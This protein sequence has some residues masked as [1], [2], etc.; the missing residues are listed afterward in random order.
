MELVMDKICSCHVISPCNRGMLTVFCMWI[1]MVYPPSTAS[2]T[3]EGLTMLDTTTTSIDATNMVMLW[4]G[5]TA[6]TVADATTATRT[7]WL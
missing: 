2:L 3:I 7:G 4:S 1:S 6:L 5:D